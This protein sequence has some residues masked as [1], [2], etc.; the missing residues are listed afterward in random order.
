MHGDVVAGRPGLA[1]AALG[2]DGRRRVTAL[3]RSQEPGRGGVWAGGTVD[4]IHWRQ[5]HGCRLGGAGSVLRSLLILGQV[6]REDTR[7]DEQVVLAEGDV[8]GVD[9]SHA[10]PALGDRRHRLAAAA[11]GELMVE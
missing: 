10:E 5:L 8:H 2:V 4:T 1:V 7:Q 9:V 3:I 6:Q 11:D